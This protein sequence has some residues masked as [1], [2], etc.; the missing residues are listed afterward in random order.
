MNPPN[1]E[2]AMVLEEPGAQTTLL[3]E[4]EEADGI[5]DVEDEEEELDTDDDDDD[6]DDDDE[7]DEDDDSQSTG[8]SSSR[9]M[10]QSSRSS[11]DLSSATSSSSS[12]MFTR[13]RVNT[14]VRRSKERGLLS[15]SPPVVRGRDESER[16][17]SRFGMKPTIRGVA[18]L[19]V[20]A[21]GRQGDLHPRRLGGPFLRLDLCWGG[22]Q[23]GGHAKGCTLFLG[24]F[25]CLFV[26]V[27]SFLFFFSTNL[28]CGSKVT[29]GLVATELDP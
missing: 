10:S 12:R 11:Y 27:C 28:Q 14:L 3:E 13:R 19:G 4:A 22:I 29:L 8:S 24:F 7:D 6:D 20:E 18:S 1:D 15:Y 5:T 16:T 25:V 9:T 21:V 17:S 2:E 26:F 23:V